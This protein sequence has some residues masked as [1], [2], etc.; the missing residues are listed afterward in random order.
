LMLPRAHI[1]HSTGS[2]LRIKIPSKKGDAAYF[3]ALK[4]QFSGFHH[5]DEA[6]VNPLTG[7]LLLLSRVD[8]KTIA[9]FGVANGL[10]KLVPPERS[11]STVNEK[12]FDLFGWLNEGIK[13]ST[14]G[15]WDIP[16]VAF[17]GLV[18]AGIYEICMGNIMVPAW[19]TAFW[20]ASSVLLSAKSSKGSHSTNKEQTG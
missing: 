19:Y 9:Q 6:Q 12:V 10:F 3:K 5:V 8:V 13:T 15:E 17:L 20:Y 1:S 4:D 18:G 2:R 16:S 11:K 14:G 7:S